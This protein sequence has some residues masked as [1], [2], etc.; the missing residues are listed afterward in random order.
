M[1]KKKF[2]KCVEKL[3]NSIKN[4]GIYIYNL[5]KRRY[6]TILTGKEEFKLI[7]YKNNILKYDDKSIG[8]KI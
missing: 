5:E 4:K 8:L 3:H 7:E 2:V 6:G 1:M